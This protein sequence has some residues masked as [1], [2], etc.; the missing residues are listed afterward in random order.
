MSPVIHLLFKHLKNVSSFVS[1]F[2]DCWSMANFYQPENILLAK[3]FSFLKLL[4]KDDSKDRNVSERERT[5][6]TTLIILNF[7]NFYYYIFSN[8]LFT[9]FEKMPT[10]NWDAWLIYTQTLVTLVSFAVWQSTYCLSIPKW[11][12]WATAGHQKAECVVCCALCLKKWVQ[13]ECVCYRSQSVRS[14][15]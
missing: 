6:T 9:F 5:I 4:G 1:L 11:S 7:Y 10:K 14:Y 8:T 2:I 13:R 3:V 15:T 12:P